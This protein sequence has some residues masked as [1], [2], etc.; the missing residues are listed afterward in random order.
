M[1]GYVIDKSPIHGKGV[2]AAKT[3]QP[4]DFIEVAII[5]GTSTPHFGKW[6][7][8]KDNANSV[9]DLDESGKYNVYAGTA[10]NVG[11]EITVDYAT[12][13]TLKQPQKNWRHYNY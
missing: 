3:F 8:H 7:N 11:E 1:K 4:G 12:E 6:L 2:F 13:P 10:I 5:N 9:I